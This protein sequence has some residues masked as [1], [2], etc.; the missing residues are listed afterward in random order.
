LD[1]RREAVSADL[2]SFQPARS[3]SL[4]SLRKLIEHIWKVIGIASTCDNIRELKSQIVQ[5]H[6]KP[7]VQF[8][9]KLVP[10]EL[11]P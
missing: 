4:K 8:E 10:V 11:R 1:S 7:G 5:I 3:P 9:L 2:L 6:G